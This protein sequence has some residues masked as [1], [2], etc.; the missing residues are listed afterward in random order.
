M[1]T[2]EETR[3][4]LNEVFE[5][6]I[7]DYSSKTHKINEFF[8]LGF[9]RLWNEYLVPKFEQKGTF[10]E[11][12]GLN[13]SCKALRI[14]PYV[15]DCNI[16]NKDIK[17][18]NTK[19][20]KFID[21]SFNKSKISEDKMLNTWQVP[22]NES[23]TSIDKNS[24]PSR[25]KF[26]VNEEENQYLE[27]LDNEELTNSEAY[28]FAEAYINSPAYDKE[29]DSPNYCAKLDKNYVLY[30]DVHDELNLRK[31]RRTLNSKGYQQIK[32]YDDET[33]VIDRGVLISPAVFKE[34]GVQFDQNQVIV[35]DFVYEMLKDISGFENRGYDAMT[36]NV[37]EKIQNQNEC[38]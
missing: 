14:L 32:N 24:L 31:K 15:L 11:L 23:L 5:Y 35:K 1:M 19:V 20:G 37:I 4:Y 33:V 28:K 13:Y 22:M 29:S 30:C 26:G 16:K 8:V 27:D 10:Y 36:I 34:A 7:K 6:Y 17:D 12:K 38:F 9:N 21:N 25:L 18:I 3:K 2:I